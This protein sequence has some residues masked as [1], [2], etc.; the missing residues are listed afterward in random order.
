MV[1]QSFED[2]GR[3]EEKGAFLWCHGKIKSILG[4]NI[5][6]LAAGAVS[7]MYLSKI[8]E[9]TKKVWDLPNLINSAHPAAKAL[10]TAGSGG[11]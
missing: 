11:T 3:S 8:F 5:Y 4:N 10:Y 7:A 2:R 6:R 9:A 1:Q